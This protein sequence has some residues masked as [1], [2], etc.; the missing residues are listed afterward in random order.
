MKWN[1][2]KY[3]MYINGNRQAYPD[4]KPG[5][6]FLSKS[7]VVG[8]LV[9]LSGLTSINYENG[10]LPSKKFEDQMFVAWI[11]SGLL[12]MRLAAQWTIWLS[13]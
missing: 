11:I 12:S 6:P 10:R 1:L 7:A 2:K 5:M 4:I 9:F 3:P 13:I 8:N